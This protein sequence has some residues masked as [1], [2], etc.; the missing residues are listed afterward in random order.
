MT[1]PNANTSGA[2]VGEENA[3]VTTSPTLYPCTNGGGLDAFA[4]R[5]PGQHS[6]APGVLCS[7]GRHA[8]HVVA[9]DAPRTGLKVLAG[10]GTHD[11]SSTVP[12]S[13][14]DNGG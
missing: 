3:I 2:L 11:C 1:S 8:V 9:E 6:M 4:N 7:K 5:T 13:S 14:L 12:S 10:Q